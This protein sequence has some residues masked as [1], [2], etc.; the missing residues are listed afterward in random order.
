MRLIVST[1]RRCR[2]DRGSTLDRRNIRSGAVI[3]D[4]GYSDQPYIVKTDDGAWLCVI[5]TG[6]GV[7]GAGGQHVVTPPQHGHGQDMVGSGGRR[8]GQRTGGVLRRAAEGPGGRVYV[9]YNHNTDNVREVIADKP[10][11]PDGCCRRVDSLGHFVFKY[12][13][14]GGRTWSAK[15][16]DVPMREFEI[17][18]KQSVRRQAEVLL[19]RG[20]RVHALTARATCRCTR[21]ADS[22]RASSRRRKARCCAATT[23]SPSA[24][25]RRSTGRR[26]PTARSACAR[27]PAAVRSPRSRA[28]SILSDGSLFCVYR[29]I[30]G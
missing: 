28:S 6:S 16:Y 19:E 24:T 18:R 29:T 4:E 5:T 23:S 22:A 12:S 20:A 30:D 8:A 15:R 10:A 11:Y 27:R 26:C 3:P 21:W 14:D 7:E 1:A 2:N 25:R 13:D 17:D 9:F